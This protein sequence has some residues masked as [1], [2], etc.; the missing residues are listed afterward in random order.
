M[1][2]DASTVGVC[3]FFSKTA[4]N[5]LVPISCL[6]PTEETPVP[7]IKFVVFHVTIIIPK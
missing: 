2:H 7:G 3:G 1:V 6:L 5:M 4:P